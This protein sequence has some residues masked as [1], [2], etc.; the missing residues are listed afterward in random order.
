M[1]GNTNG[2]VLNAG[3]LNINN[4]KQICIT[5]ESEDFYCDITVQS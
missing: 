5:F 3:K 2:K 4:T 1:Y